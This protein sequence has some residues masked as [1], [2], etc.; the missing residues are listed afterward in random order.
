MLGAHVQS[1]FLLTAA[2]QALGMLKRDIAC[3]PTHNTFEPPSQASALRAIDTDSAG[4]VVSLFAETQTFTALADPP[5]T[6]AIRNEV[7]A[8]LPPE[9]TCAPRGMVTLR[10]KRPKGLRFSR[11]NIF[12]GGKFI[13]RYRGRGSRSRSSSSCGRPA[14]A[15]PTSGS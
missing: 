3:C 7:V 12:V 1:P 10:L 11:T 15:A 9:K 5:L 4:R 6:P 14:A 8:Q 2:G 13:K